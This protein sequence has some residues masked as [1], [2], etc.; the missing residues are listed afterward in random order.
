M[1]IWKQL[2]RYYIED[3]ITFGYNKYWWGAWATTEFSPNNKGLYMAML[4]TV[5]NKKR[6]LKVIEREYKNDFW[7]S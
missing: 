3:E 5:K 1:S 4:R 2:E 6:K 7:M